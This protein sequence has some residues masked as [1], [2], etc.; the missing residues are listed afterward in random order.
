M[1]TVK[2]LNRV[3]RL[4]APVAVVFALLVIASPAWAEEF[5]LQNFAISARN[6]DGT[7]DTQAGSH[8]YSFTTTFQLSLDAGS[9]KEVKLELPPGFVG[10]PT[11]TPRCNY[12]EFA[13]GV[14]HGVTPCSNETVIGISSTIFRG[15]TGEFGSSSQAV[16]NLV[17]PAGVAAEF[18]F[19]VAESTPVLLQTSVRTGSDY[20]L[21]TTVPGVNQ[22]LHL[23][24][25]K[26]TIW[27]VPASPAHNLIR[28]TCVRP[29]LGSLG[30]EDAH[31]GMRES[32]EEDE[33][34]GPIG[35]FESEFIAE[36]TLSSEATGGCATQAP[37]KPLLTNPTSCE[38]PR[39]AALHVDS[40]EEPGDFEGDHAKTASLPPLIG[41]EKLDFS[42]TINVVPDGTAGS[43][44]TGLNIDLHVPQEGSENPSGLSE[45]DVRDTAVT[46]P[47]GVQLSPAAS[48]GL[49]ACSIAQIG[50]TGYEEL[51]P[52]AEPG[53]ET[54]QFTSQAPTCPNAAKL[55]NVRIKTPLLEHELEGAVYL[56]APQNFAGSLENPFGSLF[57]L[58]LVAEEPQAGVLIKL[59]GKVS[60]N[61]VTGQITTSFENTPQLPFSELKLE[62]FGTDRA[63]LTMPSL[64]GSYKTVA[65]F[66]PWSGQPAKEVA[67]EF[68][69]TS[70]PN[71]APC[72]DPLPF[73]PTLNSGVSNL[74][75]GSFSALTTTLS[76]EDGQQNISSVSLDYPPGLSGI[77]T[78]VPL[79]AEAQANAGTCSSASQIGEALVSVG[80]G[81]D[82]Y[83]VTGGKVYLT[84]KYGGAPFGLLIVTTPAAG[85]LVLQ[86]G[87]PVVVRAKIEV[88][89]L[90]AALTVT[91]DAPGS[92]HSIPTIIDGVPLQIK[93]VNVLIDR[94][95]FIFNPTSCE[96][97]KVTGAIDSAEGASAAVS[98]AFQVTNC[99]R[100]AFKPTFKVS[101]QA[102]SSRKLG[103]SL[104]VSLTYPKEPLGTKTNIRYVKVELPK[105]LP[106]ELKTLKEACLAKVFDENPADCPPHSMVGS[107][108]VRTQV[109]PVPLTG[110]AYFVSYGGTKF[111]E[112]VVVLQ[113]YGVT[114]DLHGETFISSK[115]ITS[116]T[117]KTTPD[118][119]FERFEL[120]LPRGEYSALAA[121]LPKKANDS[122]CGQNLVMPTTLIAQNGA[123][124]EQKTKVE[125]TGCKASKKKGKG[126]RKR[127][128]RTN[129]KPA[130]KRGH[131]RGR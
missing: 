103:A 27:G 77:L 29:L 31:S 44:P 121:N 33:L 80:L 66:T 39:T 36:P 5:A 59:P 85:P 102:K 50:F 131:V 95:G 47:E 93:H 69:V 129:G 124:I 123:K 72:S 46:L 55:A 92:P 112:L 17:P 21:T 35:R 100:L 122:F 118:V 51:D 87:K 4:S 64:C 13:K 107:V 28:G 97:A 115:G 113:G 94:P 111:P 18:G 24:D 22:A 71:G 74:N 67:S 9:L 53:V 117:F 90:T 20:G 105:Q 54:A 84:E 86:E 81:N 62:F 89:P 125:V 120:T 83:T 130:R 61:P 6:Q 91:T 40:W 8:P 65:T 37:E 110:P 106:S 119:P 32:E 12:S 57:A 70:G 127:H 48:D 76:R 56:A 60:P 38:A 99:A 128:K 82:P 14:E 15:A 49:Q 88:N 45:A 7:P 109:L 116:S 114:I 108:V 19:I 34:E 2:M 96:P 101:T 78:G 58:Y 16:Y 11:A 10:D 3:I 68:Q 23:T 63:P 1:R 41:C 73:S 98:K 25:S 75:A 104:K 30:P 42:P 26:V 126:K 52:S 43:T 79:C